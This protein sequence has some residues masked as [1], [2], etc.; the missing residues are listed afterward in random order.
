MSVGWKKRVLSS[1]GS[2]AERGRRRARQAR[3]LGEG[4]APLGPPAVGEGRARL[5]EVGLGARRGPAP[6]AAR[7]LAR[8]SR[9]ASATA[10]PPDDGGAAREGADAV[11]DARGVA[12]D[13]GHVLRA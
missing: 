7:A 3:E 2:H 12:R 8:T 11:L 9:A 1:P 5:L 10:L 13:D 4:H 6:R